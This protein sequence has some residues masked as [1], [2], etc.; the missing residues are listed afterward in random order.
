MSGNVFRVPVFPAFALT[1]LPRHLKSSS[2]KTPLYLLFAVSSQLLQAQN[3]IFNGDFEAGNTGFTSGYTFSPVG[4]RTYYITTD[5]N[6]PYPS[7]ISFHD[8]T[9]GTGN[10]FTA[11]ASTTPNVIL[12]ATSAAVLPNTDYIFSGW[13]ASWGNDGTGHDVN[14]AVLQLQINDVP[15]GVTTCPSADGVWVPFSFDWFS[16]AATS[17]VL[18]IIDLNTAG[19]GN[20]PCLDDLSF[21]QTPEPTSLALLAVAAVGLV[22]R[23][24][25]T[26][27]H[28]ASRNP[29]S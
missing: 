7:S 21:A 11:D 2:M 24:K 27:R 25:R 10:L 18:K 3:I 23:R 16:G 9:T 26:I 29:V 20:D 14:P 28:L 8:H 15:V 17:A 4:S 1:P 12:W 5:P 6:I 13:N 19:N 22:S